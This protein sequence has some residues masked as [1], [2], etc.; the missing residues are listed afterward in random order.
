MLISRK[1]QLHYIFRVCDSTAAALVIFL[2]YS[3]GLKLGSGSGLGL[4]LGLGVHSLGTIPE[5]T[6][7]YSSHSVPEGG[8]NRIILKTV[9]PCILI[10]E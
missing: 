1:L 8:M 5:S 7:Y 6:E 4:G 9:Y 2:G 10:L 3:S